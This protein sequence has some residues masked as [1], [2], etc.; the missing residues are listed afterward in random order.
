MR[1]F[2]VIVISILLT[3]AMTNTAKAE[4][5]SPQEYI[6]KKDLMQKALEKAT[7]QQLEAINHKYLTNKLW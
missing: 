6:A 7:N 3:A 1:Y 4:F 2:L 5:Y